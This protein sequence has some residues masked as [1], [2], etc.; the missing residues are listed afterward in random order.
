[1]LKIDYTNRTNTNTNTKYNFTFTPAQK[2]NVIV[3]Y[4]NVNY[5]NVNFKNIKKPI[6]LMRP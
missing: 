5:A 6:F 4:A 1:M 2:L 3:N